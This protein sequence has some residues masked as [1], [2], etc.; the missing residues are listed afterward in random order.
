M[1][2]KVCIL[3][4]GLGSRIGNISN[5][6]NKAILPIN[7]KAVVS[8]IVEKF[9]EDIEFVIAV[10]HKKDT[11][12]DYL[13]LAYPNRKFTFVEIDKYTGPGTGPG[14]SLLKCKEY[15][16]CPFIFSTSDTIVQDEVP[17][18]NHNWFGVSPVNDAENY[19][20]VRTKD[21]L[22][23]HFDIKVKTDNKL[24]FI[25][26]AGIFDF[27]DFFAT[28]ENDTEIV[29][30]ELQV[31][32]GFW[33]LINK[34]LVPLEFTW[35]DTGSFDK[36]KEADINL[37]GK[38]KAFDFSKGDEFLYFVNGRVIKF[39]AD[40]TIAKNR[41]KRANE[42]LMD[43]SPKIEGHKGNFYS[44]KRVEGKTIY[45]VLN[46]QVVKSFL[47]WSKE[48]LWI[49]VKLSTD[50]KKEFDLACKDFYFTKTEKRLKMFHD[51]YPGPD[52]CRYINGIEVPEIKDLLSGIDWDYVS[53][54]TPS[55]FHGDLQFDNVLFTNSSQKNSGD[56][57]LLDWRQDFGG[58]TKVGDLY[59]DLSKLYGGAT[60]SY[61]SIKDGKFS[62][63]KEKENVYY[64]F[65]ISNS[66]VEA[67]EEIENFIVENDFDIKKVKIITALIFLNMSPL[68]A[69]PFDLMLYYM[70][71]YKLYESLKLYE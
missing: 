20:T 22:V 49:K 41:V 15:L 68:H 56:F 54:G 70:S 55:N 18:P 51:R 1:K 10:G 45:T 36:Y 12:I 31:L 37:S 47:S 13:S 46:N 28:L 53:S 2:Y 62:F 71:R 21:N 48:K 61:Q 65:S 50:E 30:G 32:N 63:Q 7:N 43:L 59:Y 17:E 44:Y 64:D 25:G 16:Q 39:F 33:G 69:N 29:G 42:F 57:I 8:Y 67:K 52:E 66:L 27:K 35:F 9:P 26:L 34:K 11:V 40:V 14:Y 23:C 5:Y 19:C 58:L 4:A 6:A 60:I 24:A 3:T 38:D